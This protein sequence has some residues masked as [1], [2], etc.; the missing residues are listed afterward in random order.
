MSNPL[1]SH[2]PGQLK[3]LEVLQR[4]R[5]AWIIFWFLLVVF[6]II[7]A[8]LIYVAF[9][10]KA[11]SWIKIAFALLDGIVGTSI[12]RIVWYL[13]PTMGRPKKEGDR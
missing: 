7:L 8:G 1:P 5:M 9:W 3:A 12:T 11:E 10:S 4:I 13:F 2:T 6:T